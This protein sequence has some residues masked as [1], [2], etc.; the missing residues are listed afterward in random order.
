[1]PRHLSSPVKMPAHRAPDQPRTQYVSFDALAAKA[2]AEG[3]ELG[4]R[5]YWKEMAKVLKADDPD[6]RPWY[7]LALE[8]AGEL[9]T[10][11]Q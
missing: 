11:I 4:G 5:E 7:L 10:R 1:M 2:T 9:E 8:R 3:N 6:E